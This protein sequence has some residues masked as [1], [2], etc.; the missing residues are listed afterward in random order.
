MPEVR[1]LRSRSMSRRLSATAGSLTYAIR[2]WPGGHLD[3]RDHLFRTRGEGG[4]VIAGIGA[5]N[6]EP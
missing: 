4:E 2:T 5:L 3:L 6:Y 1:R